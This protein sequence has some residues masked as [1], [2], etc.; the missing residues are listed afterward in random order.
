MK[1]LIYS[2]L[3][4][5][6]LLGFCLNKAN[7]Q[8][9]DNTVYNFVAMETP[10]T[11]PGGIADFY[12][13]LG[14]TIKYPQ[15]AK[16]ENVQGNVFVSFTVEKDG[17]LNDMKVDRKL[18]AGTDEEA[19]RALKLSKRWNP[20]LLNGKPVRVKY[21][22][23]VK[24]KIPGKAMT[25]RPVNPGSAPA[26]PTLTDTTIY[27]FVSMESPPKY[28]GG[29][30]E[31]YKFLGDNIKYPAEAKNNKVQGNVFV[32]FI[33]EKDGSL[34]TFKVDRKLGSGTDEEAIRVLQSSQKWIPASVNGIPVRVKYNIPV[35]FSLTKPEFKN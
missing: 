30:M 13:F 3:F 28:P 23:P 34:S 5:M 15:Q 14:E 21:N 8:Q 31:F 24:F 26:T 27:T 29:L 9:E 33:V 19:I 1:K 17:S 10:P 11:Y 18:G 16:D 7:A 20:G 22:I 6:L 2:S 32:S 4:A 12:K 35:R 25:P